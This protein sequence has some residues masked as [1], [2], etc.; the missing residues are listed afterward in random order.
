MAK[1]AHI[2]YIGGADCAHRLTSPDGGQSWDGPVSYLTGLAAH[3][4]WSHE[5]QWPPKGGK[6]GQ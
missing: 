3:K 4:G 1:K 2:V 6:D 5:Y